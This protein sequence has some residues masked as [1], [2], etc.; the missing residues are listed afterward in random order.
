[1]LNKAPICIC[2]TAALLCH[3]AVMRSATPHLNF[4]AAIVASRA[5]ART[6]TRRAAAFAAFRAETTRVTANIGEDWEWRA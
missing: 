5:E 1:M 2:P 4:A 3:A 6:H